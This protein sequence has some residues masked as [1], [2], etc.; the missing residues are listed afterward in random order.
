MRGTGPWI[1]GYGSLMWDPGFPY[2]KREPALLRGYHRAFCI[3]SIRYRGTRER[4]GL[5]LGLDRGGSC[6]GIAYQIADEK[7]ASVF[8][9]LKEREMTTDVY[10]ERLVP[11]ELASGRR[12]RA[13]THIAD[14]HHREYA[15]K[16]PLARVAEL[17]CQGHGERG[18]C[19]DYL[20]NTVRHLDE[21][22]IRDG[23]L[24]SLLRYVESRQAV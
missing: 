17:V 16:L 1:F 23:P 22:G 13:H 3:Y 19:A 12:V 15:G 24:H 21:L 20:A 14:Q 4:P 8:A 5:V 9:Y 6:R 18:P 7:A 2:L 11:V 10:D